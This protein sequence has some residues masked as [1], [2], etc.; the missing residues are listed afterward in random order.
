[1]FRAINVTRA[2][3]HDLKLDFIHSKLNSLLALGVTIDL[4]EVIF[5]H[6]DSVCAPK[7]S[8]IRGSLANWNWEPK[9]IIFATFSR[10][11]TSSKDFA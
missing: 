3:K 9:D 11:S 4:V 8:L 5:A 1:M 6:P 10:T 7:I 2:V